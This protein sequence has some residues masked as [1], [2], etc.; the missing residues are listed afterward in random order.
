MLEQVPIAK[1]CHLFAEFALAFSPPGLTFVGQGQ[2]TPK[3]EQAATW[4]V[5]AV[6]SFDS[7]SAWFET[8]R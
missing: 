3:Q 7:R 6:A 1:G 4:S 2:R 8:K 5:K